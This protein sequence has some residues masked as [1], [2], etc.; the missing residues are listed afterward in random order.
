M[1]R[2]WF[3]TVA[4]GA[5]L[6][7]VLAACGGGDDDNGG[8]GGDGG[9]GAAGNLPKCPIGAIDKA[10]SKPVEITFWHGMTRALEDTLKALTKKFNSSQSDVKVKLV[11]QT[12]YADN[13]TKFKSGLGTG[14]LPDLVQMEDTALQ[15]MIDSQAVLPAQSCVN[16]EHYDLSDHIER[17]VQYYSV[18]DVLWPVPFN[19]SNPILYYNRKAFTAAGLDPDKPPTTLDEVRTVSE[20]IV[21]SGT[22]PFGLALPTS[23][24]F[25]EQWMA[26]AGAPYVNNGNGREDRA[27]AV[28][29]DS[30]AGKE[31]FDWLGGMVADKLA[32]STGSDNID[33]F[34]AVGNETAAMTIDTSAALG[35]ISLVLGSGQF[36]NVE[37][38]VAPMPGP[39]GEG[40]ILVGGAA[41]YIL[42]RSAPEKQEAAW[43]YAKFLNE[44]ESQAEW[45]AGTGYVP[46][47]KSAIDLPPVKKVWADDPGYKVAYD[48]LVQGVENVATAGPVI[49]DYQGVRDAMVDALNSMYTQ[50]TKPEDAL[51]RAAQRAN[52]KIEEYNSRIGA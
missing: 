36:A 35:T 27:T 41:L 29:F 32:Q 25:I 48:Q 7:L 47:R 2:S 45:H 11:N 39:T 43:R 17:V 13:L 26:K 19:V 8:G 37:L 3:R 44:P 42:N 50:G 38:D 4:A 14:D 18:Q 15:L 6:A 16:A 5:A 40:G 46:I 30:D 52:A 23:P 31:V 51:A 12:S 33:H 28:A 22:V 10:A 21:S 1:A 9:N 24:W 49:G 20:K 34:L